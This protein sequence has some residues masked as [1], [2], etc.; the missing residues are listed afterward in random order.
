MNKRRALRLVN[1]I[2]N[3]YIQFRDRDDDTTK[4]VK[5]VKQYIK[6]NLK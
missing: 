2:L 5:E 3:S 1:M 6:E 4:T